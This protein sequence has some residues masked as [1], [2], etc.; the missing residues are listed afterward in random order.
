MKQAVAFFAVISACYGD[1]SRHE[2]EIGQGGQDCGADAAHIVATDAS[3]LPRDAGLPTDSQ[4]EAALVVFDPGD[5]EAEEEDAGLLQSACDVASNDGGAPDSGCPSTISAPG[6]GTTKGW[7]MAMHTDPVSTA[8]DL[9]GHCTF[10]CGVRELRCAS[11]DASAV[12]RC[13]NQGPQ[14][15][16]DMSLQQL[17]FAVGG[18]CQVVGQDKYCVP[19]RL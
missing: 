16:D 14:W 3:A 12:R 1:G 10:L 18:A 13:L 19:P 15:F 7:C 17:C 5:A 6:T 4:P 8:Y 2:E 9:Y 11:T